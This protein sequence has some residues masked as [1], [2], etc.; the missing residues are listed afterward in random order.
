M[1]LVK[2]HLPRPAE[3]APLLKP[4]LPRLGASGRLSRCYTVDDVRR[5]ARRRAPKPVYEYVV[6]GA[7]QELN[8]SREVASWRRVEFAPRVLRD[9][10]KVDLSTTVVGQPMASPLILGPT[11]Y[12][13]MMHTDG[14][15]AVVRAA[16]AA[17]LTYTLSTMG[18]TSI[19]DVAAAA[20]EASRWFQL[21]VWRDRGMTSALV[22]R[23]REAG[24]SALVVTVDSPLSGK[25][26]RDLRNGF[27]VPPAL[28]LSTFVSGVLHPAWT[29]DLLTTDP[30]T[31]ASFGGR[32]EQLQTV[33]NALFDP[34]ISWDLVDWL[35]E[36]W[37]GPLLVKG[38]TTVEDAERAADLGVNGIVVSTHGGRQLDRTPV[39]LEVLP[40]I[41]DAV[42]DRLDVLLDGGVTTGA[43]V[44]AALAFGA[45]AVLIG[46]AYLYGLMAAG[47]P[48]VAHV[49]AILDDEMRRTMRLL[50]VTS[51]ADLDRSYASLRRPN[52]G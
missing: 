45:R 37:P 36:R 32:V 3:L 26:V 49:L 23:A 39:P 10:S 5:A 11:G 52:M 18:T 51:P 35:R 34:T 29:F 25:R 42:G 19:E 50:G 43:D 2:R 8:V 7:D 41:V 20:P 6:G 13:R 21:Y 12:S 33:V 46:R 44:V 22:E 1:A 4:R 15:R 28:S 30:P 40:S 17:G 9:V 16:A 47:E 31:F 38:I 24:Y 27:S 48:G 14:E